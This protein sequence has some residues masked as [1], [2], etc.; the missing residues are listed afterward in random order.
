MDHQSTG[1]TIQTPLNTS[2]PPYSNNTL[3]KASHMAWLT[4]TQVGG[5]GKV[6]GKECEY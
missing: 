3:A 6:S 1:Q 2:A 5:Q 4:Y